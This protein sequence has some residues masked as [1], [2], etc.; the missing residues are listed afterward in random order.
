MLSSTSSSRRF[1]SA[2]NGATIAVFLLAFGVLAVAGEALARNVEYL[3]YTHPEP[4]E[5]ARP[6]GNWYVDHGLGVNSFSHRLLYHGIG[7][8][9]DNARAA[10][11][12]LLGSSKVLCAFPFEPMSAFA[13]RHGIR[14]FNLALGF[15]ESN[16]LAEA[17][18]ERHDLRPSLVIIDGDG[19]FTDNP[20]AYGATV[21]TG[22]WVE[23][24][25]ELVEARGSFF[26]RQTLHDFLPHFLP[27]IPLP[28]RRWKADRVTAYLRSED[29]GSWWISHPLDRN[30]PVV[31]D[32]ALGPVPPW[33]K[34][35]AERV[36]AT[37]VERGARVIL[38]HV[39][40]RW[41]TTTADGV[42]ALADELGVEFVAPR[43]EGLTA[44]DQLHLTPLSAERF[45]AAFLEELERTETFRELFTQ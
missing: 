24:R 14:Y 21:L 31:E 45:S 37:L 7:S 27:A 23:D 6:E 19:F 12:L 41:Q 18:L 17:I 30:L 39:P 3:E 36:H 32:P 5:E 42:A 38:T 2:G 13:E 16:V 28:I 25:R 34:R 26:Y 10:D 20:S 4:A 15:W 35:V 29:H 9:I 43:L 8:S 1:A 40:S 33:Q 44:L 22:G 11:V